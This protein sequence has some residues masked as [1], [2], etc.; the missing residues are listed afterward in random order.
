M[1]RIE[2][3]VWYVLSLLVYEFDESRK[4]RMCFFVMYH[5]LSAIYGILQRSIA[6][7]LR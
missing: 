5:F 4:F 1:A 6:V 2:I 3:R 7:S